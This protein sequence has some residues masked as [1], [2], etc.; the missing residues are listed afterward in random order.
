MLGYKRLKICIGWYAGIFVRPTVPGQQHEKKSKK[1]S[2]NKNIH[3]VM[4]ATGN[5]CYNRQ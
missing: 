2:A 1:Q 3:I 5:T 4:L